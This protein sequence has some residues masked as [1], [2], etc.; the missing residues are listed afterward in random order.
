MCSSHSE[1]FAS[2]WLEHIEDIVICLPC[3]NLQPHPGVLPDAEGYGISLNNEF[4]SGISW[5][6]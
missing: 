6:I 2:E 3:S 4:S 1:A 5:K